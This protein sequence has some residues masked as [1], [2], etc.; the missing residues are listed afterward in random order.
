MAFL[1]SLQ[2]SISNDNESN[3]YSRKIGGWS[4][5]SDA[6]AGMNANTIQYWNNGE[7]NKSKSSSNSSKIIAVSGHKGV[8][9]EDPLSPPS[10]TVPNVKLQ[11]LYFLDSQGEKIPKNVLTTSSLAV[12][13]YR[14]LVLVG[15]SDGVVRVST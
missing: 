9:I 3:N 11:K 10:P 8:I 2:E 7:N 4:G 14:R 1:W 6:Q 15:C 12:L 13:P 5:F